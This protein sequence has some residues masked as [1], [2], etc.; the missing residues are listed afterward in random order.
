MLVLVG[1]L[2]RLVVERGV[3]LLLLLLLTLGAR[4]A[5]TARRRLACFGCH[6]RTLILVKDKTCLSL[7]M[8]IT[9]DTTVAH[10]GTNIGVTH[11]PH[12]A[13]GDA[14]QRQ[15]LLP[16]GRIFMHATQ[17]GKKKLSTW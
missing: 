10:I 6:G 17:A 12:L 8:I 16:P 1:R 3:G 11:A 14:M 15:K 7:I 13:K 9:I 4:R 2:V 5:A